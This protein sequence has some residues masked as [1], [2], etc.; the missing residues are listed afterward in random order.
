MTHRRLLS[1][2]TSRVRRFL[3]ARGRHGYEAF[4][5][6]LNVGCCPHCGVV[7]RAP[8]AVAVRYEDK[9]QAPVTDREIIE[10]V[11]QAKV[12]DLPPYTLNETMEALERAGAP[13]SRGMV[14]DGPKLTAWAQRYLEQDRA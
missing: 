9:R 6:Q 14:I 12:G 1:L 10:W 5:D 7:L 11:A 3:C 2:I 4:P 13:V 8:S